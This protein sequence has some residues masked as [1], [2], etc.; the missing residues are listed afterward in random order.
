M[1][2]LI[3]TLLS[4]SIILLFVNMVCSVITA[5]TNFAKNSA[6]LSMGQHLDKMIKATR[7]DMIVLNENIDTINGNQE[8]IY[9]K[10]QS[11]EVRLNYILPGNNP[12]E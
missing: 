7:D 5:V 11:L 6:L 10:L 2:T 9:Q 12:P 8:E 1:E 3:I 4:I